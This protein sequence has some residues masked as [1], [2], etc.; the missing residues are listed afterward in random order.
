VPLLGGRAYVTKLQV[1]ILPR[2]GFQIAKCVVK[3]T[4]NGLN[5]P[6]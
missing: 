2:I 1:W 3:V 6:F 5:T 4:L